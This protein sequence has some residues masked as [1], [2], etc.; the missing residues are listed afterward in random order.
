MNDIDY[1]LLQPDFDE[2]EE[3]SVCPSEL[4]R[5]DGQQQTIRKQRLKIQKQRRQLREQQQQIQ[6]LQMQLE[7]SKEYAA[8]KKKKLKEACRLGHDL[9]SEVKWLNS[10]LEGYRCNEELDKCNGSGEIIWK[11][12]VDLA[13]RKKK[14]KKT[15]D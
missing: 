1:E 8:E 14:K 11:L 13:P 9:A 5:S 15:N 10:K 4:N 7:R 2:S 12:L 3:T 6:E